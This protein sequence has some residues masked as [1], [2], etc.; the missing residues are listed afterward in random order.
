MLAN[1]LYCHRRSQ[2][3]RR[4]RLFNSTRFRLRS[5]VL[6]RNRQRKI[7]DSETPCIANDADGLMLTLHEPSV[8]LLDDSAHP[9]TF[10]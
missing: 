4:H 9:S 6:N 2:L 8:L 1:I 3:I 10:F 7:L 5:P